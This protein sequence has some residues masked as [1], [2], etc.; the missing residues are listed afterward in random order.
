MAR[1]RKLNVE[2]LLSELTAWSDE[3]YEEI[4][5]DAIIKHTTNYQI[6]VEC[7]TV[8]TDNK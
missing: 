6:C 7:H 5:L 3:Q 2:I 1:T 8:E 4:I